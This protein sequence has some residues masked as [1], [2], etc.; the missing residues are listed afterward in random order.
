[1]LLTILDNKLKWNN[2]ELYKVNTYKI[3][4]SQ[5]NYFDEK[6]NKK[7][8]RERW[9]IFNVDNKEIQIQRDLYGSF[10]IMNV[11]ENLEEIDRDLCFKTYDNFKNLHDKEINRLL[12]SN[13][14]KISSMGI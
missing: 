11:K 6:Y 12:S 2:T 9:N 8:L 14:K 4:A 1:M 5:Y 7:E 3:K 13:N 10:L